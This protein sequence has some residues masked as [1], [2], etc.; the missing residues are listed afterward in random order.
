MKFKSILTEAI[1]DNLDLP[2][3]DKGILKTIHK[4]RDEKGYWQNR[5]GE[6]VNTWD[7]SDG[8]KILKVANALGYDDYDHLY[9][10]YKYYLKYQNVLFDDLPSVELED[11][12]TSEDMDLLGPILL[13]F[14]YDNYVGQTFDVD[15]VTWIVDAPLGS[16]KDAMAEE[17][18]TMEIFLQSDGLPTVVSYCQFVGKRVLDRGNGF[19]IISHDDGLSEYNAQYVKKKPGYNYD[20]TIVNGY[21]E[22]VEFPKNLKKET[23]KIYFDKL[24]GG[25]IELGLEPATEIVLDYMDYVRVNQPPQ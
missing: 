2:K 24:I 16:L 20:E 10:L 22:T 14:H 9:K 17:A 1:I 18:T 11:D 25:L 7:L 12:I 15:G 3:L 8:E 13:Q 19:D 21:V 5:K 23:L 4:F 6:V